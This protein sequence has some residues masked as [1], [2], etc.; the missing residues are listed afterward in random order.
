MRFKNGVR[1][2]R[3]FNNLFKKHGKLKRLP[4]LWVSHDCPKVNKSIINWSYGEYVTA[5]VKAVNDPKPIP[6]QKNS[7]DCMAIEC[8][9]KDARVLRAAHLINNPPRQAVGN[10]RSIT[11]R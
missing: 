6:K 9:A 7:H 5:A 4:T 11:G 1:C 8:L 2:G 10:R 3:P